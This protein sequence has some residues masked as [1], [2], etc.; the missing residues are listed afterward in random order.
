[1]PPDFYYSGD[2]VRA[3]ARM[4]GL[5]CFHFACY[6]AGTPRLDEFSH[7]APGGRSAM[8]PHAF[9]ANL[10]R[11]LLSHPQ[12]GALATIG[13][14]ERVWSCSFAWPQAGRQP[15]VFESALDRL[16][17]GHPIGSAMEYFNERYAELSSDLTVELEEIKFGRTPDELALSGM[18]TANNDARSYCIIGDPAVRLAVSP[19][20]ETMPASGGRTL[21]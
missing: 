7:Y 1:V 18:W 12:G 17:N 13:H 19:V 16:M 6:A 5:V 9:L 2:D 20:R 11:K 3:D 14:V 10:P 8:A 21:K 15:Q 4:F